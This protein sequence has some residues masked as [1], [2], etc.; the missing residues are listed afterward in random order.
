MS[1]SILK[2]VWEKSKQ[3]GSKL[4]LLVA[5]ADI[6]EDSGFT[7][8]GEEYLKDKIRMSLRQTQ[9]LLASLDKDG[10]IYV[11]IPNIS[12]RGHKKGYLVLTGMEL[13]E[14][15]KRMTSCLGLDLKDA[16]GIV[17]GI[18]AKRVTSCQKGDKLSKRVTFS[19]KKGDISKSKKSPVSPPANEPK[20]ES[21]KAAPILPN[22][23][24]NINT[25]FSPERW[26]E[27]IQAAS[28]LYSDSGFSSNEIRQRASDLV[29]ILMGVKKD[30]TPKE[31]RL[32][33]VNWKSS[34]A[35]AANYRTPK[36]IQDIFRDWLKTFQA[37]SL[38]KDRDPNDQLNLNRYEP[39]ELQRLYDDPETGG[40]ITLGDFIRKQRQKILAVAQ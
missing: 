1:N 14:I 29:G 7:F 20:P 36:K 35:V 17:E 19:A 34:N 33:V 3:K 27:Y 39:H 24:N 30:L 23:S 13:D 9:R 37:G 8:A 4:L 5:L 40:P 10:E 15:Q 2:T 25:G 31:A 28:I 38:G 21:L 22:I 12:G 32:F 6:A 18:K 26:N 11:H 16:Q